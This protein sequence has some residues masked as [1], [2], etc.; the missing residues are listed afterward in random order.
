[1]L[2]SVSVYESMFGPVADMMRWNDTVQ[3]AP[4]YQSHYEKW[5]DT[6]HT[7]VDEILSDVVLN[8]QEEQSREVALSIGSS[9]FELFLKQATAVGWASQTKEERQLAV[10][11]VLSLPQ[12]PQRTPAW[13]AQGKSVLTASEFATIFGTERAVTQLAAQKIQPPNTSTN[14]LACLTHEMGPFDWGIRFEPVVKMILEARWGATILEA[15]RLMHPTDPFLAASPDG[16]ILDATDDARVGRLLEIKCPITREINETIPFEYWCQMQVQ[17]EVTGIDE[18]EY[19]EVKLESITPK[20]MDISGAEGFV[21]LF[22]NPTSCEMMYAYTPQE[23]AEREAQEFDLIETI[24]WRLAKIFTKTVPRDRAWFDG[25]ASMRQQFWETVNKLR[26]GQMAL[27]QPKVR[28]V[29]AKEGVCM[30]TNDTDDGVP[31][32]S[33]V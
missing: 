7:S 33:K 10:H 1:M 6:L 11:R 28:V 23:K 2:A 21:W 29:V 18:C 15:G 19:V 17:M 3:P 9:I 12:I 25:T 14:R 20:K 5:K 26:T 27:P 8:S 31:E 16:L 22:Q 24:P 13:Y 30:I 32:A 4:S